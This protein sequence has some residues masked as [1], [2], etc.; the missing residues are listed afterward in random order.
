MYE[1]PVKYKLN[2]NREDAT[3]SIIEACGV[4][5]NTEIGVGVYLMVLEAPGIAEEAVC[6]Q[7]LHISCGEARLLRRPISICTWIDGLIRIVYQVKGDGTK[8]LSER[9]I[10]DTLEVMGPL[11]HGFD[12]PALGEKPVFV[13]GGIGVPPMLGCAQTAK[14]NGTTPSAILGFRTK[15]AVILENDFKECCESFVTTDDGSYSRKG[16]VT[17]VLEE[18]SGRITGV[19]ACGPRIMLK[20]VATLAKKIG[21]PCEISLEERMGCGVG[22][23]LVCA[24]ALKGEDGEP[25]YGRVCRDGP[26]FNAEEVEW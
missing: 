15:N 4:A 1:N 9:R 12:I 11:G 24:C 16:V 6:G 20:G 19:A 23:C 22:A 14:R 8:W 2:K 7:F 26:V 17:D 25:H 18:L 5:E 13:G 10:G 3:L 21:L